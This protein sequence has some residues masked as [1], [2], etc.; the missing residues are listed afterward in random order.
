MVLWLASSKI[1]IKKER[2]IRMLG[3]S[4]MSEWE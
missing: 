3:F 1:A 4:L 2:E